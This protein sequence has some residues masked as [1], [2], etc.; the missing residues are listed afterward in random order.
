MCYDSEDGSEA[1]ADNRIALAAVIRFLCLIA[2]VSYSA[3]CLLYT[4]EVFAE[5]VQTYGRVWWVGHLFRRGIAFSGGGTDS[6][7]FLA[8][9][10]TGRREEDSV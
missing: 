8:T 2:A 4:D 10:S 1:F 6:G 3:L 5:G 7:L 9:A